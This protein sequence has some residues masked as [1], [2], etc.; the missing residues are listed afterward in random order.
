MVV[1]SFLAVLE[2]ARE[3]LIDLA[4]SAAFEPIYVKIREAQPPTLELSL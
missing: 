3:S 2:L 4:Q 1:V